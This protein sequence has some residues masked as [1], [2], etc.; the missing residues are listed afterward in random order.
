MPPHLWNVYIRPPGSRYWHHLGGGEFY[1][2]ANSIAILRAPAH[3]ETM[4]VFGRQ[5]PEEY[6]NRWRKMSR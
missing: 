3:A 4:I 5:S 6:E 2:T 1:T